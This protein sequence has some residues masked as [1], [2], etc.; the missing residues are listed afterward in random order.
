MGM[1]DFFYFCRMEVEIN[2]MMQISAL[3][4]RTEKYEVEWFRFD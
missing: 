1:A 4:R 2:K 3:L